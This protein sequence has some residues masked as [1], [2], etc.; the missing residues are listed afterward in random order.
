MPTAVPV[1]LFK[2]K[3]ILL[4]YNLPYHMDLEG[5]RDFLVLCLHY[6]L[7][8]MEAGDVNGLA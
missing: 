6:T 3:V 8:N 4:L 1:A 7:E 5:A 2:K